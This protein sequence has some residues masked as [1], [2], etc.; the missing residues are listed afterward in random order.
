M[1]VFFV[2]CVFAVFVQKSTPFVRLTINDNFLRRTQ[3][4]SWPSSV[5]ASTVGGTLSSPLSSMGNKNGCLG[6]GRRLIV[7]AEMEKNR[8]EFVKFMKER[9]QDSGTHVSSAEKSALQ[10]LLKTHAHSMSSSELSSVTFSIG[11]MSQNAKDPLHLSQELKQLQRDIPR[12]ASVL[13]SFEA[14]SLLVGMARMDA[15]WKDL[16]RDHSLPIRISMMLP[17]MDERGVGDVVWAVGSMGAKWSDLLPALQTELLRGL[18][19]EGKNLNAYALSSALWS[20]AKMGAKWSFFSEK[21]QH[22]YYR[23]IMELGNTMSPQQSSKGE[24]NTP[25]ICILISSFFSTFLTYRHLLTYLHSL[26]V[27]M[28]CLL[29]S[30]MGHWNPWCILSCHT[31]WV[32]RTKY[33]QRRQ[34][35]TSQNGFCGIGITSIDR[36]SENRHTLECITNEHTRYG[37]GSG[38]EGMSNEYK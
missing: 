22:D 14:I 29:R 8:P 26:H 3:W 4:P 5:Y 25:L 15:T 37:M 11:L 32:I 20:M 13:S 31:Y 2:I 34:N 24:Y 23:R 33:H 6:A 9:S 17:T 28:R 18:E 38:L 12:V 7:D 30:I 1:Q 21:L 27:T 16:N 19:R 36:Y 35:Q 10:S